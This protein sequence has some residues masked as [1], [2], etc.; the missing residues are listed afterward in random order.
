V[1]IIP[2][3]FSLGATYFM[4]QKNRL[5]F[6]KKEALDKLAVLLGGRAAEELFVGDMSSGAQHDIT[7]ATKMAR[8]MVCEWGMSDTL[9]T[10]SYDDRTESGQYLGMANYHDKNYSEETAKK[11]DIEVRSLIDEAHKRAREIIEKYKDRLQLMADMLMEF[12]TLDST[13]IHQIMDGNWDAEEK[14]KRLKDADELQRKVPPP[15]PV[16]VQTTISP[17]PSKKET[18]T[19]Q[20]GIQPG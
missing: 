16:P 1:T 7:Q 5:S 3:G 11:I 8:S 9:G 4:P 15:P 18:Q 20:P 14:R 13:D 17:A 6:W 10:V 2:R 12:E 19:D